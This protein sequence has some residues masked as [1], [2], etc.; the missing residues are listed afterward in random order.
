MESM[1]W[2]KHFLLSVDV[3]C[4]L[5][6]IDRIWQN[7]WYITHLIALHFIKLCTSWLTRETFLLVWWSMGSQWENPTVSGISELWGEPWR[8]EENPKALNTTDERE[9][10]LPAPCEHGRDPHTPGKNTA[11]TDTLSIV[12]RD[13]SKDPAQPWTDIWPTETVKW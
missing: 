5:L 12:F 10:I 2:C 11:L 1:T 6:L 7:Y 4:V 3:T 9:G 13:L 8:A